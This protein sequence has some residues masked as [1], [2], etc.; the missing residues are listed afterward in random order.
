MPAVSTSEIN[1]VLHSRNRDLQE[2]QMFHDT[3]VVADEIGAATARRH[4]ITKITYAGNPVLAARRGP[5]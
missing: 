1:P 4:G 3:R 5:V 2:T